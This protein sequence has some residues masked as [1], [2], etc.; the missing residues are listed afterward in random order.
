MAFAPPGAEVPYQTFLNHAWAPHAEREA[1][2]LLTGVGIGYASFSKLSVKSSI[3]GDNSATKLLEHCLTNNLP[4]A[5]GR[6]RLTYATTKAGKL[7][8]E[9]T[10]TKR[11]ANA[12]EHDFYLVGSRDY[13]E[14]DLQQIIR[15]HVE[16]LSSSPIP[17][18]ALCPLPPRQDHTTSHVSHVPLRS[19]RPNKQSPCYVGP[20]HR[21]STRR[22]HVAQHATHP[23]EAHGV[24]FLTRPFPSPCV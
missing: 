13:A 19:S 1:A 4:K 18:P 23:G 10:V 7:L 20:T 3:N 2:H 21:S 15:Y 6:C 5:H 24:T 14:H 12:S 17:A 11:G 9:F 22:M 8:A 16:K